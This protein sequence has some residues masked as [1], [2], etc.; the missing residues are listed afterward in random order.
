MIFPIKEL[1]IS[2]R[3]MIISLFQLNFLIVYLLYV[4]IIIPT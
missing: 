2:P 3:S 4:W 1:S